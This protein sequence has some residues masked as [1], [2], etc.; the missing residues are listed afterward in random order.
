ML[1]PNE[2]SELAGLTTKLESISAE[3]LDT[4]EDTMTVSFAVDSITGQ[5]FG[6]NFT[7]SDTGYDDTFVG[8]TPLTV[9]VSGSGR[10]NGKGWNKFGS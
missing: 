6:L 3:S 10:W 9:K 5:N 1:L 7:V 4:P 8:E 2:K